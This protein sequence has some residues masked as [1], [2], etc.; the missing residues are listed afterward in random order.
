MFQKLVMHI[1][2][3]QSLNNPLNGMNYLPWPQIWASLLH[4]YTQ[5][6]R[7]IGENDKT[8]EML[9]KF[10]TF[11]WWWSRRSFLKDVNYLDAIKNN[12]GRYTVENAGIN[13]QYSDYENGGNFK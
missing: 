12:S 4:R 6:L 8:N 9:K 5:S 3:M 2:S 1:T 11:R 10:L 7:A 13:S